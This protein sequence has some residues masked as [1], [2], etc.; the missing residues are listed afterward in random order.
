VLAI[1]PDAG[2]DCS[3]LRT[4]PRSHGAMIDSGDGVSASVHLLTD[5]GWTRGVLFRKDA[6][7]CFDV[8]GDEFTAVSRAP[9]IDAWSRRVASLLDCRSFV[10]VPVRYDARSMARLCVTSRD[11]T[12]FGAHDLDLLV[13]VFEHVRPTLERL[14]IL[15]TIA[16][17]AAV[18]ERLRV[19]HDLHDALIQ[20]W[21][22]LRM[23]IAAALRRSQADEPVTPVLEHLLALATQELEQLREYSREFGTP[24]DG[25]ARLA[26]GIRRI[27]ARFAAAADMDV[28]VD[29]PDPLPVQDRV[30]REVFHIV[31]EGLSNVRRHTEAAHVSIH[32]HR[33]DQDL[34]LRIANPGGSDTT[35]Q[36]FTPRSIQERVARLGGVTTV[37]ADAGTTVVDVRIPL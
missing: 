35:E 21:I 29:A 28:R 24:G 14:R 17:D 31:A 7:R 36:P 20:P 25:H 9:E 34:H 19:A 33:E 12:A 27:A 37:H 3:L 4:H 18:T 11:Q 22:G 1:V 16:D 30:A 6:A 8:R 5:V 13:M 26:D 23:G 15:D 2:G 32:V 10:S